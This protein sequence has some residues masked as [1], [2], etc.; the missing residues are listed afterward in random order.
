[1]F[2]LIQKALIKALSLGDVYSR[3]DA[4]EAQIE[5]LE[6]FADEN[7]SLWQFLDEQQEIDNVF[8]GSTEEYETEITD[9]MLRNM[10]PQGDA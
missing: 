7:A 2:S 1:M 9:M 10:K 4:L 8:V 5:R 3:I 6:G